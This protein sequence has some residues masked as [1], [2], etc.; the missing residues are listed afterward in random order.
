[1]PQ[2]LR[3]ILAKREIW[4]CLHTTN[5]Q[6]AKLK[7]SIWEGRVSRLLLQVKENQTRM[8]SEQIKQLV[9]HY[10]HTSL[11]ECEEDRLTKVR[12][13]EEW[14]AVSL[15][16]TN[17]LEATQGSLIAN[18]FSEVIEVAEEL[19]QAHQVSLDRQ[20]MEYKRLCRE[21]L[22]ARQK[23][24]KTE[25]DR[26]DGVYWEERLTPMAQG[27]LRSHSFAGG[28]SSPLAFEFPSL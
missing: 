10:I 4:K 1:V 6:R 27:Q 23:I 18:D 8:T 15:G 7:A 21:L 13:E 2:F 25:L 22:I 16:Y 9:Q 24:L 20:S 14:A 19:L 11:Q 5:Y 26:I 28:G 3:G 12:N 17:M